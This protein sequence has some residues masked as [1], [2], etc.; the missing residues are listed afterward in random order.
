V[1]AGQVA[2]RPAIVNWQTTE[3]DIDT[4]VA[5]VR[6]LSAKLTPESDY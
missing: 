2:L 4:F 5:V 3:A 1:Y 6:E